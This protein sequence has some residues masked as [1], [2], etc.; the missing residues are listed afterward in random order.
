MQQAGEQRSAP[1][2]YTPTHGSDEVNIHHYDLRLDYSVRSNRLAAVAH[3]AGTVRN[4]PDRTD[5]TDRIVLD[6]DRRLRVE[7]VRLVCRQGADAGFAPADPTAGDP[8]AVRSFRQRRA[9]LEVLPERPLAGGENFVLSIRY[10]GKPRPDAGQWGDIG[11]EELTDGVLVAGQPTGAPSWFPCNDLPSEKAR[12][13]LSV[14]VEEGYRVA[15][16]GAL[17]S[18]TAGKGRETWVFEQTEPMATYLATV[19]IGR[20]RNMGLP[21]RVPQSVLVPPSLAGAARTALGRQ[22][23]MMD[24]FTA[25]FGPYP[26]KTYTVVV[27]DDRLEI[28]LEAQSVSVFGRNHLETAGEPLVAHE[29]AHQWFGN[30]VTARSWKDIWLHEG[31]ATYAEWVW[32]EAADGEDTDERAH[33]ELAWLRGQRQDLQ[34]ADP[35]PAALFDERVYRRGAVALHL[36]RRAAGDGAF[37]YL[38]QEWTSRYRHGCADT[39]NFLDL[40]ERICGSAGVSAAGLLTPWLYEQALPA[41]RP[42]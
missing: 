21:G 12:Y 11:W 33:R 19:Q 13:R 24:L 26:F 41:A 1:D 25:R 17:V 10:R 40:A 35:G 39:G 27:A 22:E 37:F 8:V 3:L 16:N 6:L 15:G 23:S 38:L 32:A 20:Y 2:P 28:P 14:T 30:S 42:A 36:L 5:R 4:H 18:R 9:K 31:F 7:E 34:L 29:L